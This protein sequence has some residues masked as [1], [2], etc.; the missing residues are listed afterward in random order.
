M[1]R[2]EP[3]FWRSTLRKFLPRQNFPSESTDRDAPSRGKERSSRGHGGIRLTVVMR[4]ITKQTIDC[5]KRNFRGKQRIAKLTGVL[6]GVVLL[7]W[8]CNP[9]CIAA[10]TAPLTNV[11]LAW[12]RSPSSNVAGYRIYFGIASGSYTNSVTVGSV[13]NYTIS[14]LVNGVTY[15]FASK[16]YT[17]N[18]IESLFSNEALFVPGGAAIL[19]LTMAANRRANLT[20][21]GKSGHRYEIQG[22]ADLTLWSVLSTVTLVTGNTTNFTDT[23]APSF[24]KRYYRTRDTTP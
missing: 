10:T 23:N 16:A 24:A 7:T 15:F 21:T 20:L 5:T 8:L 1:V 2:G 19:Q 17:T 6:A 11:N 22:S 9:A 3:K 12:N 18:G 14:N 4:T 13:T